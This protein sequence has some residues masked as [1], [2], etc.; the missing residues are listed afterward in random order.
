[1][2][3]LYQILGLPFTASREDIQCA[4]EYLSQEWNPEH[5]DHP[6]ASLRIA[7]INEAWYWLGDHRRRLEYHRDYFRF[8]SELAVASGTEPTYKDMTIK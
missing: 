8:R 2:I 7:D 1:M 5:N 6:T 3:D 4:Y